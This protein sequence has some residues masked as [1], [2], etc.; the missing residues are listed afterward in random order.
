MKIEPTGLTLGARITGL[1]LAAPLSAAEADAIL[2]ALGRHGVLCFPD[3]SLTPAA[4]TAFTGRLGEPEHHVSDVGK[5]PDQPEVMVLSNIVEGGRQIGLAQA[6]RGWHTDLSFCETVGLATV[7]HAL[8]VPHDEDGNPLGGT[9]FANMHAAYDDLPG[10]LKR[11]L[12]DATATHHFEKYWE[13]LRRLPGS[14][15][16]PLNDDQ[17]RRRPPIS[18]PLFPTHPVTGRKVLYANPGYVARIDGLPPDESAAIL[19]ELFAHQQRPEYVYTH[20]W[21]EGDVV[22]WDN[23]GT[24]HNAVGDYADDQPRLMYRCQALADRVGFG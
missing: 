7:L 1:D 3:Q 5:L 17:R 6:G 15:R 12:A 20:R 23:I 24:I 18:Q 16:A 19:A 2:Q 8:K 14:R 13:E 4:L 22:V 11:R 9:Q 10:A 21:A